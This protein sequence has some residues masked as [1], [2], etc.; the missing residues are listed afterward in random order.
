MSKKFVDKVAASAIYDFVLY[1]VSQD[2]PLTLSCKHLAPDALDRAKEF[3]ERRNYEKSKFG[4]DPNYWWQLNPE[5]IKNK[6]KKKNK[7]RK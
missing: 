2:R 7:R 4:T 3:L 6:P 5:R 1:M